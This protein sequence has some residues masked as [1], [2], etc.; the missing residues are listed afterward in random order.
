MNPYS[1]LLRPMLS[2]K[3]NRQQEADNK[4]SFKV[5][6]KATKQDVKSAI[7]KLFSVDVVKVNTCITRAKVKRRGA[8]TSL[9]SNAKKA[10]VTLKKDQ[11]IAIFEA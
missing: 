10:V 6:L 1:V 7:E 5:A 11:K 3:S 8:H 9:G 2:E 4:Y